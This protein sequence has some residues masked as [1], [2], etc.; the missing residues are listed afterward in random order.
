MKWHGKSIICTKRNYPII[1]RG[2]NE[3]LKVIFILILNI[4][5]ILLK[6]KNV[7]QEGII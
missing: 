2:E 4:L 7:K 3:K 1:V 6:H 5:N